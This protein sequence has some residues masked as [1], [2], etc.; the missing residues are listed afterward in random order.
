MSDL[1]ID[2]KKIPSAVLR[3]LI[4]EVRNEQYEA[5]TT[6]NRFHNRHFKSRVYEPRPFKEA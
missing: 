4:E 1:E 6:Y 3:E 5:T 2:I